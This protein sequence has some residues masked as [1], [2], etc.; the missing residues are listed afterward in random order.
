MT[1]IQQADSHAPGVA[2]DGPPDGPV[3]ID[4]EAPADDEVPCAGDDQQ[5]D[6]DQPCANFG[7]DARIEAVLISTDR[8]LPEA[9]IAALLGISGKGAAAEIREAIEQLNTDYERGGRAFEARRLAGGWQILTRPEFGPLLASL[10]RD[11]LQTHLTPAAME[12]L[13]IVAYRQPIMRAEVEAI[14]GV[15]SGEVLRGLLERRLVKIV[16]RAEELGRPMLYGTTKEFLKVF[17]LS[18]LDDLPAVE[19]LDPKAK[20]RSPTARTPEPAA[21]EATPEPTNATSE[22]DNDPDEG[23]ASEG[24]E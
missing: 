22:H 7:L 4:V 12:S 5:L 17:G 11:K 9:R 20:R 3:E 24:Q 19:G 15:S 18:G 14:R 6:Q 16:G 10:H 21:P 1:D 2:H 8:P 23:S 13:A